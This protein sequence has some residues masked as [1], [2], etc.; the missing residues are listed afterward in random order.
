MQII[1]IRRRYGIVKSFSCFLGPARPEQGPRLDPDRWTREIWRSGNYESK[2]GKTF[3][4]VTRAKR[5]HGKRS[6]SSDRSE[7]FFFFFLILSANRI[8]SAKPSKSASY[9]R[10]PILSAPTTLPY[11]SATALNAIILFAQN[12][13]L[14]NQTNEKFHSERAKIE[15]SQTE[16]RTFRGRFWAYVFVY[17]S[18]RSRDFT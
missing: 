16:F 7:Y 14:R 6:S 9:F 2:R 18:M 5:P 12:L 10:T 4:K 11:W 3:C 17:K 15:I 1:V 13:S 8:A